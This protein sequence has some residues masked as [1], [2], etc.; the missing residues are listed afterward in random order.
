MAGAPS[1]RG[2][3]AEFAAAVADAAAVE[4]MTA[5]QHELSE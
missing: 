3:A 4:L 5:K 1:V 2:T